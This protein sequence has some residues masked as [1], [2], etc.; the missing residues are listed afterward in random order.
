MTKNKPN[1]DNGQ[2]IY[3]HHSFRWDSET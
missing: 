1:L 2:K 3:I